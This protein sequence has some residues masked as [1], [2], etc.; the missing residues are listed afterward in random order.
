[1]KTKIYT[2]LSLMLCISAFAGSAAAQTGAYYTGVYRNLFTE[3]IN[4]TDAQVKTKIDGIWNHFF[5]NPTNKVYTEVGSDMAYIEDTGNNDVRT[6]GMSYGMMICVQLDKKAEFDRLWKWTKTY[7]QYDASN[8][9]DGYFGWQCKT[10]GTRIGNNPSPAPDGE[11]YFITAL[12]FA[13]HRWGNGTG[14]YDY[15]A[16]AQEII[17][18][19]MNKS[20]NGNV[21]PLFNTTSNLIT[22]VPY[23]D[24]YT[25]TDPSYNLPGFFELWAEWTTSNKAKLALTPAAAR[26]LLQKSS[27]PTTGLFPDY[28]AFDGSPF[29][30]SWKTDYDAKRY[31]YDAIRCALNVGMDYSWYGKDNANQTAMMTRLLTFF[32]TKNFA[33]GQYNWD[34]TNASG[35]YSE[36][37][38]G[39]NAVGAIAL[40]D[41]PLATTY[42]QRLWDVSPPTGQYRYYNGLVYFLSV[43]NVSGDF[44]I[45]KPAT[46]GPSISITAPIGGAKIEAPATL[47]ITAKTTPLAGTTIAKVE[48]YEGTKL[49]GE[50]TV[51]PYAVVW[52]DIPEGIHS[53]TAVATDSK[54]ATG[55]SPA[56]S[57]NV[58]T[59]FKIYKTSTPITIDGTIDAIWNNAS[60]PTASTTKLVNGTVSNAA[61]LSGSFKALWDDTYLYILA[62]ITDDIT[63]NESTNSYDDDAVEIYLDINNNKGTTYSATDVQY[64]FGWDDGTI[65]GALPTGRSTAGITYS[66]VARTGG[67]SIEARIPWATVQGTPAT[68]QLIGIDFMVNDDDDGGERDAKLSWNAATDNAWQDPSLFGTAVLETEL[69]ST[70]AAPAVATP[71]LYQLNAAAT[72]L[73]A[74]GTG[75]LWYT[76]ATGGTGSAVAPTPL[77]SAVSSTSY[78]VSQTE[79]GCESTRAAIEVIVN[80]ASQKISL[81][82]GWNLIGCPID[83]TTDIAVALASIWPNVIAVKNADAF[84]ITAGS[85]LFNTLTQL[86]YGRGYYVQISASCELTW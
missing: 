28:S 17:A 64:T 85:P 39:A 46:A 62:D 40:T 84:Y 53:I 50:S 71:V 18:K 83:D 76:T 72:P 22:F 4:K 2:V 65:V 41:K 70:P 57:F 7:M 54:G 25:H 16:Q 49:L 27:H 78:Y 15:E 35:S 69:C 31:Q 12:F 74:T 9:Y 67:Y 61:D 86:E 14:I 63:M 29:N 68:G 10:D 5:V 8:S 20:G 58:F 1:M 21:F 55:T 80:P 77:T 24:S 47:T 32:E 42:T 13:S 26:T 44:K 81:K 38:A 23:G 3:Y 82:P 73:T 45:W 37:M 36:G 19:V 66:A 33:N 30:P 52:K 11:A 51:A 75:L 79:N 43:L 6:E 56:V 34:G 48:Y 60:I 59:A